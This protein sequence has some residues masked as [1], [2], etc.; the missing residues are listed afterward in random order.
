MNSAASEKKLLR[1]KMRALRRQLDPARKATASQAI[2]AHLEK[3][4]VFQRARVFHTYVALRQEV[5]NHELIRR[6]LREGRRVAVP[7]VESGSHALNQYFIT[8]FSELQAG[9][10][11]I[12]EPPPNPSRIAAPELFDR[13]RSRFRSFRPSSRRR[14]RLL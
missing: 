8:D 4:P 7:K 2:V 5:D 11:G 10:Y 12:L 14:Q 1:E 13:A 6:L 9:A 3:L